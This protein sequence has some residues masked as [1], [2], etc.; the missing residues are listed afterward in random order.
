MRR[1]LFAIFLTLGAVL[2]QGELPAYKFK[3]INNYP[4]DP[5]AFTEGLVYWNGFLF[6][7]TGLN[8]QSEIRKVELKSGKV[9]QRKALDQKYFGEGITL[10]QDRFYQLSWKNQEGFIYDTDFKA[11][12]RFSYPTEGWGLT[13]NG[14]QLIMS[15]GTPNLYFLNARTLKPERTVQVTAAGKPLENINELEYIKG[16]IYANVWQT[17]Q[18]VVIDPK[19]GIV[20]GVL[21]LRSL[22]LLMPAGSDVLNGI[23]YDALGDRLFVTGKLWP[24]VF[25][26]SILK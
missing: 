3:V 8:G 5:K 13:H 26:I 19:T 24:Y 14:Q 12:G 23:A 9:L 15:D 17:A 6:E 20:E 2:A 25:E 11:V 16:K 10:F 7:G 18:I 4:H 1:F 21:D 22:A